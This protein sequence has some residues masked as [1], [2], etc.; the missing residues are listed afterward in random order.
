MNLSVKPI[1]LKEN[2]KDI[3]RSLQN[4]GIDTTKFEHHFIDLFNKMYN[5]EVGYYIFEQ[6][7]QIYKIIILPKTIDE[8]KSNCTKRFCELFT[9][10]S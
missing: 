3:F 6:D 4:Q 7:E 8:K 9:S 10:L 1:F 5:N 2:E